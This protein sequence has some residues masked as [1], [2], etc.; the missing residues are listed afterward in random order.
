MPP[1]DLSDGRG[2]FSIRWGQM[3]PAELAQVKE[4]LSS[5]RTFQST[6]KDGILPWLILGLVCSLA[7]LVAG[8]LETDWTGFFAYVRG[9]PAVGL[10]DQLVGFGTLG[11]AG[12]SLWIL[13]YF[14][15]VHNRW[16]FLVLPHAVGIIRG[17]RVTLIRLE[18]VA[19]ASSSTVTTTIRGTA[20]AGSRSFSVLEVTGLDG[21]RRTFY[22][23]GILHPPLADKLA[24][25]A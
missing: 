22:S 2:F 24:K 20:G 1:T 25:P 7:G 10:G 19:T 4:A 12:V 8:L 21:S 17:A 23:A 14:F 11:A 3:A 18:D 9:D 13:W 15:R 6:E 5:P 16:G